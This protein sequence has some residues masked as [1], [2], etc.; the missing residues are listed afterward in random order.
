VRHAWRLPRRAG[1]YR[2]VALAIAALFIA[3]S[4]L[5]AVLCLRQVAP[6]GNAE[7][8]AENCHT[9]SGH[10]APSHQ[11]HAKRDSCIA[12]TLVLLGTAPDLPVLADAASSRPATFALTALAKPFEKPVAELPRGPPL[13]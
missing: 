9:A 11:D 3:D 6:V 10:K 1:V 5:C 2:L 4:T 7:A 8:H 12:C 13:A